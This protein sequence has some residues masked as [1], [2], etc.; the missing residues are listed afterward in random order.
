M[1]LLVDSYR[2][3]FVPHLIQCFHICRRVY[4]DRSGFVFVD[5]SWRQIDQSIRP[6]RPEI[7]LERYGLTNT[8]DQFVATIASIQETITN[9]GQMIDEQQT[10]QVPAQESAQFDTTVPLHPP[11]S[12]STPQV[13]LFTLHSQTDVALPPIKLPIQTSKDPH[14][15]MDRLEQRLRQMRVSDRIITWE[16]FDGV[17]VASLL[18]KFRMPEIERYMGISCPR[19]HLRFYRTIYEGP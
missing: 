5:Q 2:V 18:A 12:H 7:G 19:I 13:I 4:C 17:L 6:D 11:P 14:T 1:H 16:D 8:V 9:L 15:R 10:Q 3:T